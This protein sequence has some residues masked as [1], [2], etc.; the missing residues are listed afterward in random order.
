MHS[1]NIFFNNTNLK[2]FDYHRVDLFTLSNSKKKSVKINMC[3][4][5]FQER[6][7]YLRHLI[8]FY[9]SLLQLGKTIAF[10]N[11]LFFFIS[12]GMFYCI[13]IFVITPVNSE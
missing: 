11:Y 2:I 13:F 4:Y 7:P 12:G 3:F 6:L 9:S 5:I 10:R 1:A 8:S